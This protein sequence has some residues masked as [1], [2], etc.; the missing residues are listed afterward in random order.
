MALVSWDGKAFSLVTAGAEGKFESK[1]LGLDF[2]GEVIA[3]HPLT[4][5]GRTGQQVFQIQ[6]AAP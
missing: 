1:P 5:G 3:L 6:N 4:T 2:E